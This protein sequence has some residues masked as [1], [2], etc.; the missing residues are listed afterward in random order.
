MLKKINKKE[1]LILSLISFVF[2]I[3]LLFDHLYIGPD[4]GFHI[5]RIKGLADSI[6]AH[7]L[8]AYI[9][10]YTNNGFGYAMG[11]FYGDIFLY[12]FAFLY[13]IGVPVIIVWKI[14]ITIITVFT[15][16]FA[17]ILSKNM[18]K[19]TSTQVISV[20]LY[21][22]SNV[23]ISYAYNTNGLGTLLAM[24]FLPLL[25]LAV[26]KMFILK[27]EPYL[28]LSLSFV[29]ILLSHL[30][31]FTL[32]VLFFG[33]L[34]IVD[35]KNIEKARVLFVLKSALLAILLSAFFLFPLLEQMQSQKFW[36]SFLNTSTNL[37]FFINSQ[38]PL[39]YVFSDYLFDTYPA[40]S[41]VGCIYSIGAIISYL[42]YKARNKKD[43]SLVVAF[44]FLIVGLFLESKILPLYKVSFL[45]YVQFIYRINIII[46][47][48]SVYIIGRM[49]DVNKKAVIVECLL[50][51]YCIFNVGDAFYAIVKN[52]Y[53]INNKA[54]YEELYDIGAKKIKDSHYFNQYEIGMGEY[55]PYTNSYPYYLVD[56][57]IEFANE[58]V[59]VWDYVR[60]GTTFE[61]TTNYSYSDYIYL[62]LSWY[63]GYYY[64][65]INEN[66]DIVFEKECTYNEYS[67]RVG[68]FMENGDHH[69]KVYYKGTSVQ[70]VSLYISIFAWVALIIYE[71]NR[72]TSKVTI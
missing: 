31:S 21:T 23:R 1:I 62:P 7:Q 38:K 53:Q 45:R 47:T 41:Y 51:G 4:L 13:L 28:L 33:I 6:S 49:L 15:V 37:D 34:L 68:M 3:P 36:S 43:K 9:S 48:L 39:L 14:A 32:S 67:R 58:D 70:H 52:E 2:C 44:V 26:Y 56:T 40:N 66:G 59:A 61:F 54:D 18:F 20:F 42:L 60:I 65:E 29:C 10:P 24:M 55:L 5:S 22:M 57:N 8:P 27:E 16:I 64:Q 35:Y 17:F 50:V 71:L 30:L 63:K 46:T 69:Y 19:K 25:L 72:K 11:L 12:P